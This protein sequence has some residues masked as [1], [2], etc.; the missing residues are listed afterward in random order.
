VKTRAPKTIAP[1]MLCGAA[2]ELLH[3]AEITTLFVAEDAQP[4]GIVH[5][6]DFLRAGVA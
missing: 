1:D 2:L 5:L 6:H 4:V 3:Q